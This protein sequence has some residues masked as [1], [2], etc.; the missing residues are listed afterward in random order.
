MSYLANRDVEEY[1]KNPNLHPEADDVQDLKS[2][3]FL[4]TDTSLLTCS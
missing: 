3:S 4:S 1:F 2:V